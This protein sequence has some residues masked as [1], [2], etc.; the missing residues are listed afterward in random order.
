MSLKMSDVF[1]VV[2]S[3]VTHVCIVLSVF[4]S[5]V[6]LLVRWSSLK[7]VEL[8]SISCQQARNETFGSR[9]ISQNYSDGI[10]Y[11]VVCTNGLKIN[12][13]GYSDVKTLADI[14]RN[15]FHSFHTR[16]VKCPQAQKGLKIQLKNK[17]YDIYV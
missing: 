7:V 1:G 10:S 15:V 17:R 9:W 4:H 5:F 12:S 2:N 13:V 6:Q 11:L 14:L 3:H 16:T 8:L